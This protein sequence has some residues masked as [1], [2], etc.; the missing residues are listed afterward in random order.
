MRY[1]AA[2]SYTRDWL[3]PETRIRSAIMIHHNCIPA[4]VLALAIAACDDAPV[5]NADDDAGYGDAGPAVACLKGVF[6]T[7]CDCGEYLP[8]EVC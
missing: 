7:W 5:A 6:D 8:V 1:A 2:S 3:T 4:V